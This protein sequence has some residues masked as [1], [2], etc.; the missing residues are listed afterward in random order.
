MAGYINTNFSIISREKE[1]LY[2][3]RVAAEK[4]KK[5]KKEKSEGVFGALFQINKSFLEN[6]LTKGRKREKDLIVI[7][8][9]WGRFRVTE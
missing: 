7:A 3:C 5:K 2:Q 4:K 1:L 6:N 8:W 9:I